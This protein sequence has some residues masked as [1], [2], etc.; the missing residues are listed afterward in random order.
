MC[1]H[2]AIKCV[3]KGIVH[4]KV[5]E[6]TK[7]YWSLRGLTLLEQNPMQLKSMVSPSSDVIKQQKKHNMP[8]C[9]SCGVIQ[10]SASPDIYIQLQTRSY[11]ASFNP[12][13]PD[14]F[15]R[16]AFSSGGLLDLKHGWNYLIS[17]RIRMSGLPNTWM[18]PHERYRGMFCF[19]CCF[20]M[21][22]DRS[23]ISYTETPKVF[24]GLKHF[25]PPPLKLLI[26]KMI[27]L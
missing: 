8:P 27:N 7:H 10:V 16:G 26:T 15:Q 24:C 22:E 3:L 14:I 12:K 17:S 23:L 18:T 25:T 6:S 9:C 5:F 2:L 13:C 21:S 1:S 19:S 4:P 11:T 20:I